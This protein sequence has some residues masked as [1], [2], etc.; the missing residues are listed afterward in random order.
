MHFTL[1]DPEKHCDS[2]N[3][4]FDLIPAKAVVFVLQE[5]CPVFPFWPRTVWL[6]PEWSVVAPR[7]LFSWSYTHKH[8]YWM[9]RRL[10]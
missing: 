6:G 1:A 2:E 7:N 3:G 8:M 10:Y 9:V 5:D 4:R